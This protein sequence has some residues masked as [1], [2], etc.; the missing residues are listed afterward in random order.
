MLVSVLVSVL[1]THLYCTMTTIAD[2]DF[3]FDFEFDLEQVSNDT[4]CSF[5]DHEVSDVTKL[6]PGD[7]IYR[8]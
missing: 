8:Q 2:D 4:N 3:D 6:L 1:V 7:H 5:I